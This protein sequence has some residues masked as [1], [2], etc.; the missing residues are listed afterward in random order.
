MAFRLLSAALPALPA[1]LHAA[2]RLIAAPTAVAPKPLVR[3][4]RAAAA[5]HGGQAQ[6]TTPHEAVA[7]GRDWIVMGRSFT[8]RP[9]T[10]AADPPAAAIAAD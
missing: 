2:A 5:A 3:G 10:G 1:A 9:F 7:G 6:V 4:I 8:G